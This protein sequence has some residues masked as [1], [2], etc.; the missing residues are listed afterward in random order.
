MAKRHVYTKSANGLGDFVYVDLL[1]EVK[2]ARQFNANV[3]IGLLFAVILS[4]IF[5]YMPYRDLTFEIEELNSLNNDLE[6]ELALTNEEFAGYEIDLSVIEFQQDI[7][8][9][10]ELRMNFN[11]LI[12]D[13]EL[14]VDLNGGRIDEVT[15]NIDRGEINIIVANV[16]E[17]S[18]SILNNSILNLEWVNRSNFSTPIPPGD[19]TE[20]RSTFTIGVIQDVE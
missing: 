19:E 14:I 1:P 4:F 17:F 8:N 7:N 6:H 12:D 2:R 20:Y 5:I 18:F 16:N 15:Y 3:I 10:S 9:I 13:L 11:N